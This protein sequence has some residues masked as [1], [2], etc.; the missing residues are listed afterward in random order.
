MKGRPFIGLTADSE[1]RSAGPTEAEFVLRQNYATA[2]TAAGGLPVILP[3]DAGLAVDYVERLDGLVITG[4]MF[5]ISPEYYGELSTRKLITKDDRTEFELALLDAALRVDLPVLGI[6]NGS[7]LLA[8]KLGG[9]LIQDIQ[10]EIPGAIE[11]L[12]NPVPAEASH[13][14]S[15][16]A[17]SRLREITGVDEAKVNSLHH[18]SVIAMPGY[19]VAAECGSDGVV[20]AI[21]VAER[22]FCMGVQW[23][24]EYHA[25]EADRKILRAFVSEA[26]AFRRERS[27][28]QTIL[29]DVQ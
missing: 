29:E 5:D 24:P 14:I 19:D 20:E 16:R 21:E 13:S 26:L 4:G 18:Q 7:Q 23:H 15:F 22:R 9:K 25:S 2:I 11:H 27:A 1:D 3:H 6:C 17:G 28:G 12:P 10:R 8:V